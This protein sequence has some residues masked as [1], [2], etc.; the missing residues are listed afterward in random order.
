M[1]RLQAILINYNEIS[2]IRFLT[3][4]RHPEIWTGFEIRYF[5]SKANRDK[6]L[7]KNLI[8]YRDLTGKADL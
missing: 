2:F 7:I 6:W 1:R 8:G 3:E 4:Y 5:H